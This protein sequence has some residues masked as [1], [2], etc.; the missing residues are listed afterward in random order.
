MGKLYEFTEEDNLVYVQTS[1]RVIFILSRKIT[2][3]CFGEV[4][5]DN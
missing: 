1:E 4:G 3:F 5:L 2:L